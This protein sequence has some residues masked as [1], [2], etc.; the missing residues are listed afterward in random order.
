MSGSNGLVYAPAIPQPTAPGDIV[1][2][3][4][5]NTGATA[6]PSQPLT[7][8]EEFLPGAVMP[9]QQL[10]M[11]IGGQSLP[12]QMDAKTYN[13]DGSVAMGVLTVMAPALAPDSTTGAMLALAPASTPP[14]SPPVNLSTALNNYSLS[15]NVAGTD[16]AGVPNQTTQVNAVA[17]MQA[18]LQAGRATYWQ[19]GPLATQASVNIPIEG[20]SYLTVNITAYANGTFSSDVQ[21]NNDISMGPVGGTVNY[22]ESIVQDGQVVSQ[23]SNIT[24]YQYQNWNEVVGTSGPSGQVN[25]QHDLAYLEQTGA[26][27]NFDPTAGVSSSFIS[28]EQSTMAAPGWGAPL[29]PNGVTQ[30]MEGTGGRPDI[31]PTTG[32][33]AAWLMTQNSTAAQFALGQADAAGAVPWNFYYPADGQYL[34]T[35][36]IPNIW[37]DAPSSDDTQGTTVLT[38]PVSPDTGW[39]VDTSHQPDLSY[40]AYLMTGN[41]YYLDE[42]NAQ[43]SFSETSTWP[44]SEARNNGQGLVVQDNEVRGAAWDLREITEAAMA[45]PAG[46]PAQQYFLQMENNNYSW[47]VSQIPTWTAEEGQA[48]G[49]LPGSYGDTGVMPPWEQDYLAS[50]VVLAAEQG[51]AD[52]KTFLEWESNFLVGRFL[53]ASNGFNPHDGI[54]YNINT[55]NPAT[56]QD[57]TTWA[58]IEQATEAAGNSNGNGWANSQGD[59]GQL[60]AQSLAGI[61]TVTESPQAIEAYGWL[62]GSGAPYVDPADLSNSPQFDI[63]PRLSDGNLLTGNNVII[64]QDT[65]PTTIQGTNND[66]L[67]E[68]GS[69]NDT[70][71][72][73]TGIN[74]LFGGSG[75]D[76]LV[77]GSN[78]DYLYGGTGSDTLSAGAGTNFLQSGGGPTTFIFSTGDSAQNTVDG[79]RP[80]T[81]LL[82]VTGA[83]GTLL[84]TSALQAI[85]NSA[86]TDA[87]GNAVLT[88]SASNTLTLDGVSV[89]Q[90]GMDIFGTVLPP[91]DPVP[92]AQGA[93]AATAAE[94]TTLSTSGNDITG[95]ASLLTVLDTVGGNTVAG[96]AGGLD[97]TETA[98][99]DLVS[100]APGAADSLNLEGADTVS[101]A[102]SDTISASGPA[103][104]NAGSGNLQFVGG[105]GTSTIS[106]GSGDSTVTGGSG[107]LD[108]TG[109]TGN[110]VINT[111][112]GAA[113]VSAGA[114]NVTLNGGSGALNYTGGSGVSD[115]NLGSGAASIE[116]GGG[117]S[118]FSFDATAAGQPVTINGFDFGKD[119]IS[120]H[121]FSA[122]PIAGF[123][124]ASGAETI[125]LTDGTTIT[126]NFPVR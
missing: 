60:A 85:L 59:Y 22:T 73:G 42:L 75:N 56:G 11:N 35:A 71:L 93:A 126:M 52:A 17:D 112:T 10:V 114:A 103:V 27:P 64:S 9:G 77:G 102:G 57:Y 100:T 43:A 110:M 101:A 14:P 46:S 34:N 84:S 28:S 123:S 111:G 50:S 23:Q 40:V 96:G 94:S 104:V 68:A 25:I 95:G 107:G 119:F 8:G 89:S 2:L 15:V 109:G 53:N 41:E 33:N 26:V 118:L 16:S 105:A 82:D 67:I 66:Q 13:S 39:D 78:N 49:Y 80:G 63:V 99:S 91:S 83:G 58:E 116:A 117:S 120:F 62:L 81:D 74:I 51:N 24:Q 47:L 5:Q 4:L 48:Y 32:W 122:D 76:L 12:V 115:I 3:N 1:G 97:L 20:S 108:V 38:Q 70:V 36:A 61:I 44:S 45:N 37:A 125:N 65:T 55:Y 90:L 6:T 69:G 106:G 30:Q 79:F 54:A 72:G 113:T 21:F 18:A 92:A 98:G 87:S 124:W 86:T 121:N 7:F 29:S 88:L 31:G 19:Q